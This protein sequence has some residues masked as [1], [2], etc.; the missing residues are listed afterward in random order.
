MVAAALASAAAARS[1]ASLLPTPPSSCRV[2]RSRVCWNE[3]RV[4]LAIS[5][6]R[7]SSRSSK[8]ACATP[9]T[10][11]RMTPRCTS[12][13]ANRSA[14]EASVARRMRP[15]TSISHAIWKAPR[16]WL[17]VTLSLPSRVEE[18]P[19]L[20]VAFVR[21]LR[22]QIGARH[23]DGVARLLDARGDDAHVVAVGQRLLDQ[24]LEDRVLKHLP[25]GQVGQRRGVDG[26]RLR[27]LAAVRRRRVD[28]RPLVVGAE[29]AAGE[30]DGEN[31]DDDGSKG[32]EISARHHA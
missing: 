18:P 12:S 20:R 9:V 16:N 28:R 29:G 13:V 1:T 23:A 11:D 31:R 10:S 30:N 2:N 3:S 6:S 14:S 22:Q 17:A 27:A 7:S 4:R 21:R 5:S 24:A 32:E 25:P 26:C 19:A 8:Y 15:Q